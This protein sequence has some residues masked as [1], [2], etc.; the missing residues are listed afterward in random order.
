MEKPPKENSVRPPR[1][2]PTSRK[3]KEVVGPP[4][5][6]SPKPSKTERISEAKSQRKEKVKTGTSPVTVE[7]QTELKVRSA[8]VDIDNV[9]DD[10]L[11]EEF[12]GLLEVTG[13][14]DSK[15]NTSVFESSKA[16][17]TA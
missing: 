9:R 16:R 14:E 7:Q 6:H 17:L 11:K 8:V 1:S 3:E 5:S 15:W 2:R 10:E 13:Q 4:R 12:T